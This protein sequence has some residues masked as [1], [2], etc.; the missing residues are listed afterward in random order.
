MQRTVDDL[1]NYLAM[2]QVQTIVAS[3]DSKLKLTQ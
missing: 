3:P 2:L 1:D